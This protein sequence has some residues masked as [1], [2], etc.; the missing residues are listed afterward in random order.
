MK[1]RSGFMLVEMLVA[2][3]LLATVATMVPLLLKTVY[4]QRQQ[5]RF[6]RFA[7][8]ELANIAVRLKANDLKG[9]VS[10]D[11]KLSVWFRQYCPDA[12]VQLTRSKTP[13]IY[14]GLQSYRVSISRPDGEERPDL[15]QAL[16]VWVEPVEEPTE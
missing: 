3:I 5:E 6:F 10:D 13:E 9:D 2:L 1:L 14:E 16:T 4:Q 11:V 7:Q 12:S 15:T 8:I